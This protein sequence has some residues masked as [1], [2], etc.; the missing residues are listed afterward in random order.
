LIGVRDEETGEDESRPTSK[1]DRVVDKYGLEDLKD[2]QGTDTEEIDA[3]LDRLRQH[4]R[5]LDGAVSCRNCSRGW[6]NAIS[7]PHHRI[8]TM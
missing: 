1:V 2:E 3:R 8:E 7:Q 5:D 6:P 4:K